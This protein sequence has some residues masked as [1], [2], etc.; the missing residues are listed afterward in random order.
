MSTIISKA[1]PF[2]VQKTGIKFLKQVLPGITLNE[3]NEVAKK[4]PATT[5]AFALAM[6]PTK[7]KDKMPSDDEFEKQSSQHPNSK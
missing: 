4:M 3:I 2:P 1:I 5:N 6:A 7:R